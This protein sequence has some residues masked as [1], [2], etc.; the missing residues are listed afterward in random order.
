E[1][2]RMP[3]DELGLDQPR[4]GREIP[5]A[6]LLQEQR[7]EVDLEE[8]VAQLV[9]QL[10]VVTCERGVCD[11]VRLLDGVRDDRALRLLTVPRTLTAQA[12]GQALQLEERLPEAGQLLSRGRLAGRRRRGRRRRGGSGG[13]GRGRVARLVAQRL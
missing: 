13:S 2:V 1:H 9:E 3:A 8:E 11:L 5:F 6:A 7:E 4:S 12:L 10:L